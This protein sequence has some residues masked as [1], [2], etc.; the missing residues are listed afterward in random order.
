WDLLGAAHARAETEEQ[1]RVADVAHAEAG[2]GDVLEDTAIHRLQR[3][4]A[5]PLENAIA[6]SDVA[7][8][9]IRLGA[10]FDSAGALPAMRLPPIVGKTLEAAVEQR[11][12]LVVA[13]DVAICDD[14]VLGYARMAERERAFWNDGIVPWPIAADLPH[15]SV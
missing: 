7:K 11:S 5:A 3:E 6:D 14:D 1:R 13:G 2:D 12:Q 10:A 9:A 8:A 4:A 15:H